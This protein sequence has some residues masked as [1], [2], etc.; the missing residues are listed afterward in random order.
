MFNMYKNCAAF[1]VKNTIKAVSRFIA[2][3]VYVIN[4]IKKLAF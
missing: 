1:L 4:T 2:N 3:S